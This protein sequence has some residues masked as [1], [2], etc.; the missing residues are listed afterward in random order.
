MSLPLPLKRFC[1]LVFAAIAIFLTIA[2]YWSGL[3]GGFFFDDDVN[4][5]LNPGVRLEELSLA[6]IAQAMKSGISGPSGRPIS[7]LSFGLSYF[8]NG[9]SPFAFK[10]T[11]LIVHCLNGILV[12]LLALQLSKNLLPGPSKRNMGLL[13]ASVVAFAWLVHPIQLTS[14]LYAVQRMTSLSALFLLAALLF[15]IGARDHGGRTGRARL[16]VAWG[17]LWP[18]AFLSK[19]SGALF[20]LFALAW[21]LIIRRN[22]TG[23]LD[24]L[25]RCFA[26][27]VGLTLL[28]GAAYIL[29]PRGHWL[30]AGYNLRPFSIVERLMTEGRVLWIYVGLILFPRLKDLGLYHDDIAISSSLLSPWTTL[31]AIAGLI[32]L[33]WLAWRTRIKAP[34]FSFGLAW[35]LIGHGLESTVLPLEIAHEHRNY[36]P[37]FG[38]LLAGAWALTVALQREGVC[39]TIGATLAATMLA[40]FALVT[41]LRAHQFGEEGRRTQIEAQHHRTSARAQHEAGLFLATLADAALPNSPA[42]SFAASHYQLACSLDPNSKMCWLGLI[43]LNCKAGRP[44]KSAWIGELARRLQQTPFSHGDRNVLYSIKEMS[45]DGPACL[46]RPNVDRL[47]S[48]ALANPS[49]GN[50]VQS[51]LYSWYSDYLWLH[52]QDM[53][54]ARRALGQSLKLDPANPSNR[55]KWA[56]LLFIAGEREPA[57]RLLLELGSENLLSDDRKTLTKLLAT[58]N[59]AK[60]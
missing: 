46:D 27:V 25:A 22:I 30:W 41:A 11:N 37:L 33:V 16:I 21:E 44:A 47:F 55:L 42:Y 31:P 45:I 15:H 59:I 1:H 9:F 24:R 53:A 58:Y 43:Q 23:G 7:Q 13:F 4:I 35:F 36:I 20:P 32:S 5:R 6:A 48:A 18:L 57:R 40:H 10:L 28:A 3:H 56:Q 54:A 50:G 52:E 38:V 19:E 2:I 8:F 12:F 49:V 17:L 26:A 29:L 39:K 60:H 51:I 34:L 14:V